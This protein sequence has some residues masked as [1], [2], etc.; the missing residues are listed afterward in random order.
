MRLVAYFFLGSIV[1]FIASALVVSYV[2]HR[3]P[4]AIVVHPYW[5]EPI[6]HDENGPARP[7]H[8]TSDAGAE[9]SAESET[10]TEESSA[11]PCDADPCP[12]RMDNPYLPGSG[13]HHVDDI[14]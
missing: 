6:W 8:S 5:D 14:R 7:D 12:V 1:V 13:R 9:D 10:E 3:E 4:I 2:H 11:L